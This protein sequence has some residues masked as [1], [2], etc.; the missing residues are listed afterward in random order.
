[1]RV[2]IRGAGDEPRI[3]E[4]AGIPPDW[5]SDSNEPA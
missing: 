4:I 5:L 1:V 2:H 3:V